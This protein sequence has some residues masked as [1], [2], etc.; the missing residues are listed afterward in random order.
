LL[1]T[2]YNDGTATVPRG[3]DASGYAGLLTSV[4]DA[5][6]STTFTYK[7]DSNFLA[8]EARTFTGV[9]G[10][11]TSSYNYDKEGK[12]TSITYP[13]GR[14][15]SRTYAASGGVTAGQIASIADSTT[16]TTVLSVASDNAAG[17][18]LEQT[19]GNSAVENRS[20][21][22]R[23]QL[24]GITAERSSVSLM[25][26]GY[27]Y[28]T[29]NTGR[30]SSRTDSIQPEHSANYAYDSLQRLSAVNGTAWGISW[31]F[32]NWG[33]RTTQTPTVGSSGVLR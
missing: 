6:G 33:N 4:T 21:N 7:T 17:Q 26:L 23:F 30:I 10:T 8:S 1:T 27:G 9:S 14:Q 20:F 5:V 32:D 16:S 3:Y 15:V 18:I 22:S 12:L 13:S 2:S 29:A 28:G 24:T 11:F 19:L 25:N 31:G